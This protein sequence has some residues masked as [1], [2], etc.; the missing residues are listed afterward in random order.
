[1]AE[2]FVCRMAVFVIIRDQEHRILLQQ[3]TNT[4]YLDEYYD[5]ACSG[6]VDEGESIREATVREL[7]EELGITARQDD[8]K[9]VHIN[10]NFIDVPYTNFTFVLDKWE[11]EPSVCEPEKCSNLAYFPLDRLPERCTPSVRVNEQAGFGS[12]LTYSKVTEQEYR[13]LMG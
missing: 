12:E 11:G 1:M 5:L 7:Q 9:L 4:G 6:H 10:Q 3:R 8:L 13:N 2:K